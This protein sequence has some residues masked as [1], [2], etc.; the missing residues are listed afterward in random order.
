M[1]HIKHTMLSYEEIKEKIEA[2]RDPIKRVMFKLMYATGCRAGELIQIKPSDIRYEIILGKPYVIVKVKTEKN[3]HTPT[4]NLPISIEEEK[5]LTQEI[6]EYKNLMRKKEAKLMFR[7]H[8]T[9]IW[10][11][12]YDVLNFNPHELRHLRL[13]HKVERDNYSIS[14]LIHF[15]GWTDF[16]PA[17]TYIHLNYKSLV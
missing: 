13:T 3:P 10:R 7:K 1:S 6:I 8:R 9:T 12:C 5:W 15:A 16:K 4:R 17:K 11:Y 2:I 14:K